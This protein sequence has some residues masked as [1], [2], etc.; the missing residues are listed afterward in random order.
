MAPTDRDVLLVLYWSAN[1]P[2]WE[3][4]TKWGSDAHLSEWHGVEVNAQ[5]RVVKLALGNNNLR[6]KG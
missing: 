5:D 4:K 3:N 2:Y 6:G 1:G